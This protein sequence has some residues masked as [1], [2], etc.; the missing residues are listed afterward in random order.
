MNSLSLPRT[1]APVLPNEECINRVQP[2]LLFF[3]TKQLEATCDNNNTVSKSLGIEF[4]T[5][6]TADTYVHTQ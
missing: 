4:T 6:T 1:S 2:R 3:P 5:T